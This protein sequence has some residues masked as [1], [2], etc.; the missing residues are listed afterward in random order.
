MDDQD[1]CRHCRCRDLVRGTLN[2]P[3]FGFR[4]DGI[5]KMATLNENSEVRGLLCM[6]CGYIQLTGDKR[7]VSKLLGRPTP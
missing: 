2:G 1:E 5:S 4:P 7:W 3:Q 6:G